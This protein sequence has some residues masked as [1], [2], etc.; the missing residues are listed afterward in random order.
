M[1]RGHHKLSG[2]GPEL[3]PA[4]LD[5]CGGAAGLSLPDDAEPTGKPHQTSPWGRPQRPGRAAEPGPVAVPAV[6]CGLWGLPP[7]EA[8]EVDQAGQQPPA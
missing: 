5:P 2:A 1:F 7:D 3:E 8:A 6:C 4:S